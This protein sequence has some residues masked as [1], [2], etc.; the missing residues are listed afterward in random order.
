LIINRQLRQ[1]GGM[2][3]ENWRK[4]AGAEGSGDDDRIGVGAALSGV[5]RGKSGMK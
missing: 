4:R 1:A 3:S 5:G 2:S